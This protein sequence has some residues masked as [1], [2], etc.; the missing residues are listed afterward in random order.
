[1]LLFRKL[2]LDKAAA[3]IMKRL[4][5]TGRAIVCPYAEVGM[6][7]DKPHQ[8]ELLLEDLKKQQRKAARQAKKVAAKNPVQ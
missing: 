3:N 5:I 8:F 1:M 4:E 7:V 6:D 2:T